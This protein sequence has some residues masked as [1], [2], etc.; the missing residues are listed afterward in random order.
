MEL[1]D[2][3]YKGDFEMFLVDLQFIDAACGIHLLLFA[4]R[5]SRGNIEPSVHVNG[6]PQK[7]IEIGSYSSSSSSVFSM[8]VLN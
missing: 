5:D 7:S 6:I 1:G 2:I 4:F 8:K 3:E